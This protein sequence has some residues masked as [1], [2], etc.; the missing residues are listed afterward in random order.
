MH[1][2][3]HMFV[4]E[5]E[6]VFSNMQQIKGICNKIAIYESTSFTGKSKDIWQYVTDLSYLFSFCQ[7]HRLAIWIY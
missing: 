6:Q 3:A 2:N 5:T 4:Q 1:G 7:I